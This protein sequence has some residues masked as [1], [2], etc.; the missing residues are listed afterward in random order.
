MSDAAEGMTSAGWAGTDGQRWLSQVDRF[1][2][3]LMPVGEAMLARAGFAP[4]ERVVDVGCG[5]GW[6]TRAI[7]AAVGPSGEAVGLDISPDLVAGAAERAAAEGARNVRFE[8]GDAALAMPAGAPFDRLF[9]RFGLMFFAEPYPA[10][11]N[12]RRMVRGGGRF[13]A[14]VWAP[15]RENPWMIEVM[16]VIGGHIPLPVPE[17]RQPGPFALDDPDYVRDLLASA[18]FAAIGIETWEGRQQIGGAGSDPA[19]AAAFVLGAMHVSELL[20]EHGE[21]VRAAVEADLARMF[22]R[23]DTAEGVRMGGKAWL[24]T[25]IAS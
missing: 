3:M 5:G 1:E 22:A 2:S 4:G 23:F 8:Q 21:A 12:L 10:F 7:A 13:D 20:A 9:S 6:T 15:A 24:V 18:G 11:A 19:A 25:A 16:G 17:P 14:A